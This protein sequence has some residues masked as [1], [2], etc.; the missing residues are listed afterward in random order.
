[1]TNTISAGSKRCPHV[2]LGAGEPWRRWRCEQCRDSGVRMRALSLHNP[3]P[4]LI[5]DLPDE[6]WKNIENRQ[7]SVMSTTG[8]LLL[9]A[10]AK[11]DPIVHEAALTIARKAG[12]PE[13]LLPAMQQPAMSIVGA[14]YVAQVLPRRSLLDAQ[15]RWKFPEHVGYLLT[16]RVRLA[17]RTVPGGQGVFHVD[18]TPEEAELCS[19]AGMLR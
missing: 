9:H 11:A 10:A 2:T 6:H 19:E 1:M 14:V 17:P 8:P 4:Y 3:Y 7:R 16:K 15:Y 5:L 12:V 18:L 13:K